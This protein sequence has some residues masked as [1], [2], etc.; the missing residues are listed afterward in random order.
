M[1]Y[2]RLLTFASAFQ[3]LAMFAGCQDQTKIGPLP[4]ANASSVSGTTTPTAA[5]SELST[6][7]TVAAGETPAAAQP[8]PPAVIQP[9]S[10]AK[11]VGYKASEF[12][13]STTFPWQGV[14]AGEQTWAGIPLD[15]SGAI[16]LWGERSAARNMVHP[17]RVDGI[18]V[19]R[20]FDQL[21][22]CHAAFFEAEAGDEIFHVAF[23]YADGVTESPPIVCGGDSKD[24]FVSEGE[25]QVQPTNER[26]VLAWVG[27]GQASGRPQKVRFLLTALDNPRPDQTVL[28]VDL[29]SNKKQS[30]A[31]I[32]ALAAGPAG[33]MKAVVPSAEEKPS[34]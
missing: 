28:A 24:W 17:D 30:A 29:I 7:A 26:S 12:K 15:I 25:E 5:T 18:P 21:Y 13:K 8:Q 1:S 32:V 16:F 27:E 6:P 4:Q 23:H 34:E 20:M 19:N 9:I 14:P 11:F 22:V 3:V 31:C 33:M 10:L 2:S